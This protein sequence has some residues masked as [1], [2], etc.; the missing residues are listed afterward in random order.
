MS[1]RAFGVNVKLLVVGCIICSMAGLIFVVL[2]QFGEDSGTYTIVGI[3]LVCV[4]LSMG[5]IG[6]VRRDPSTPAAG[7]S[8]GVQN[9]N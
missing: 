8:G 2:D 6:L 4:G 3:A 5:A 9:K 1:D 7:Q